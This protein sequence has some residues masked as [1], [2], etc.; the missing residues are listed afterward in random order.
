MA[1]IET[2]A[3]VPAEAS[4]MDYEMFGQL[5]GLLLGGER[6]DVNDPGSARPRLKG[7]TMFLAQAG[8]GQRV[9]ARTGYLEAAFTMLADAADDV[10]QLVAASAITEAQ[11]AALDAMTEQIRLIQGRGP[12][13]FPTREEADKGFAFLWSRAFEDDDDWNELR[14]RARRCFTALRREGDPIIG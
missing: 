13:V 9:H 14:R 6:V 2:A 12:S 8:M 11:A 1:D 5:N 3:A 7:L 4:V 10:P